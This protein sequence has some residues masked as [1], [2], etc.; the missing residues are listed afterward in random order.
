[1]FNVFAVISHRRVRAG[2]IVPVLA[3]ALLLALV[4]TLASATHLTP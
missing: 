1:M 4:T 2:V 3:L